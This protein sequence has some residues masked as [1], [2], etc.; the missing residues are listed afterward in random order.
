[1]TAVW[2][3]HLEKSRMEEHGR[4]MK[5]YL[6]LGSIVILEGSVHKIM[7]AARGVTVDMNGKKCYYDYGACRYPEGMSDGELMYFNREA[8][9]EVISR[10]YTDSSEGRIMEAMEKAEAGKA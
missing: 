9:D 8:V 2:N 4:T 6:P 5:E 10:G 1:M 7:I 3:H